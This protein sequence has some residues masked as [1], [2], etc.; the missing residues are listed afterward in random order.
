VTKVRFKFAR[1]PPAIATQLRSHYS[2]RAYLHRMIQVS[3]MPAA[4]ST[5]FST[6][7]WPME[8]R[9]IYLWCYLVL[10]GF[11]A[12]LVFAG[13]LPAMLEVGAKAGAPCIECCPIAS[14]AKSVLGRRCF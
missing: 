3:V 9:L 6:Q 1:C 7:L 10:E 8:K 12:T 4:W 14:N 5:T 2:V 13:L 11:G